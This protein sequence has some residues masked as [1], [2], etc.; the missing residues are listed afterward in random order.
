M[1]K[2]Q[3]GFLCAAVSVL[4]FGSN[5]LPVKKYDMGDGM[6]FQLQQALGIFFVGV[7]VQ[8]ARGYHSVFQP[9]AMF[10]GFLWSTG[11]CMCTL[12]IKFVGLSL[13]L[14]IWGAFNMITGWCM[15]E[16]GLLGTKCAETPYYPGM[17]V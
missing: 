16:W 9:Y 6:F 10:G 12:I 1:S 11:N 15:G 7:I 13:G 4:G 3:V 2:N 5:F 17:N 8:I 14:L